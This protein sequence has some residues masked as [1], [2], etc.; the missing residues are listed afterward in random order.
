MTTTITTTSTTT[1]RTIKIDG[2]EEEK[3]KYTEWRLR[4]TWH[5]TVRVAG[6]VILGPREARLVA[7]QAGAH[8]GA[9]GRHLRTNAT[10]R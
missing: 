1:W 6:R 9:A 8:P 2:T 5:R 10:R 7:A 4:G 3:C